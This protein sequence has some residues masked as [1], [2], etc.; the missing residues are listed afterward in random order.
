MWSAEEQWVSDGDRRWS[1]ADGLVGRLEEQQALEHRA[2]QARAGRAQLVVVR[3]PAGIG[4]SSLVTEACRHW[5]TDDA[6]MLH[7]TC[8]EE[9][10]GSGYRAVRDLL[11]P[12]GLTAEGASES[13]LLRRHAQWAMPA[14]V[15]QPPEHG[16]YTILHGLYW[17][18]VNLLSQ[19]PL[20]VVIDDAH[21]C[22]EPSLRWV[23]FLLR[24]TDD[25]P[26]F[27]VLVQ[28]TDSKQPASQ[29][30]SEIVTQ[31]L[32]T[33]VDVGPLTTAAL[34]EVVQRSF[35]SE[36]DEPFVQEC[37][38]ISGG[39]P[40]LLSR[41]LDEL[42]GRGLWPVSG[43]ASRVAEASR[44]VVTTS[45][46]SRLARQPDYVR[47]VATAK[48]VLGTDDRELVGPLVDVSAAQ[49][50]R[51]CDTLRSIDI[52]AAGRPGFAHDVVREAVLEAAD[53]E[54]LQRLRARAAWLLNSAGRPSD[55]VAH[56]LLRL[57]HLDESWM[58]EALRHAAATAEQQSSPS[59]AARYLRRILQTGAELYD[60][61]SVQIELAQALTGVDPFT[62]RSLFRQL[63]DE[64]SDPRTRAE[65]ALRY[66]ASPLAAAQPRETVDVLAEVLDHW[67]PDADSSDAELHA[68]IES[69]LLFTGSTATSTM[70]T[71]IERAR[72]L[73][74]PEG[75]TES[76]LQRLAMLASLAAMDCQPAEHVRHLCSLAM[77]RAS[78]CEPNGG[79]LAPALNLI[80]D[81]ATAEKLTNQALRITRQ[82]GA[83]WIHHLVLSGRAVLRHAVGEV[84]EAA[85]DAQTSIEMAEQAPWGH[86]TRMPYGALAT[87]LIEQGHIDRAEVVLDRF[88]PATLGDDTWRWPLFVMTRARVRY[89][90]GDLDGALALLL[91]CQ[92]A[93]DAGVRNPVYLPWR[94]EAAMVLAELGRRSQAQEHVERHTELA[95][96]WGTARSI[97][98]SLVA[99]GV[100]AG[101]RQ[102]VDLLTE[103]TTILADSPARL[104][105]AWAEYRLGRAFLETNYVRDA[106]KRLHRAIDL[107]GHCGSKLLQTAAREL[108]SAAGGR[109]RRVA[110]SVLDALTGSERRVA[111]MAADGASNREIA[112]AL[113]VT[114]RTVETHL[115]SVY[116]K[117]GVTARTQLPTELRKQG[118][119]RWPVGGIA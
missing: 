88:D 64:V 69:A 63:L 38:S 40:L 98:V 90:R 84:A 37:A 26:L 7:A 107:S 118:N 85:A 11:A 53:A 74:V 59:V 114:L 56:H 97:G 54:E 111:M 106:R 46:V 86:G 14:L 1:P 92:Q 101:G 94:A 113:F 27:V 18:T 3:G 99:S 91:T 115:T 93:H 10:Q 112:E 108:L 19:G 70:A 66:T 81:F 41:L 82:R 89:W 43:N 61:I 72:K 30:L 35:G 32:C 73:P 24:R 104:D 42:L 2:A 100:V 33:V 75:N 6:T 51:A 4:K 8:R 45:V 105:R 39:N 60:R 5:E 96:R 21:W 44:D 102:G 58:V 80:D 16:G 71:A 77:Q 65:I 34:H 103:A 20:A 117:L 23:E 36:P 79:M 17:L 47:K 31:Q 57:S 76:E 62:A 68:N 28:R 49:V 25:L 29:V 119:D 52:L 78:D 95:R 67:Q 55:Q 109:A 87:A 12:L 13:P 110:D 116:R 9:T 50:D 83:D 22:D 15:G 48:A